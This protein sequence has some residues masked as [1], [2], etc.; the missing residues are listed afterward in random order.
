MRFFDSSIVEKPVENVENRKL[1]H[2]IVS[3]V[4]AEIRIWDFAQKKKICR[5]SNT[6]LQFFTV[7]RLMPRRESDADAA[8]NEFIKKTRIKTI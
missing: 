3:L 6:V 4:Y 1:I 7:R 5:I 2:T 8:N